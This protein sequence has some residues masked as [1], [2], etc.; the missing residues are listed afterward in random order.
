MAGSHNVSGDGIASSGLL[1]AGNCIPRPLRHRMWPESDGSEIVRP[2][3]RTSSTIAS[4]PIAGLQQLATVANRHLPL[5]KSVYSVECGI[6][7]VL[8]R[9][10]QEG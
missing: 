4:F 3:I 9:E 10:M 6:Y 2:P 5:E 8:L 1:A 7:C